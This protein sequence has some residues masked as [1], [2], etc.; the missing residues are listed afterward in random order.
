MDIWIASTF[1]LLWVVYICNLKDYLFSLTVKKFSLQSL[2]H[3]PCNL[4]LK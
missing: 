2:L 4:G 3:F 1:Y